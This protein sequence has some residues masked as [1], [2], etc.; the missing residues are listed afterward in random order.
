MSQEICIIRSAEIANWV[1]QSELSIVFLLT[2]SLP[3]SIKSQS[4]NCSVRFKTNLAFYYCCFMLVTVVVVVVVDVA[5][6]VSKSANVI[7]R[8]ESSLSRINSCQLICPMQWVVVIELHSFDHFTEFKVK[9][10]FNLIMMT[11]QWYKYQLGTH[12]ALSHHAFA[13]QCIGSTLHF[14]WPTDSKLGNPNSA[15]RFI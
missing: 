14:L 11:T 13:Q 7:N 10:C 1:R 8:I 2:D 15:L 3:V 6:N 12:A 5:S 9:C 4:I